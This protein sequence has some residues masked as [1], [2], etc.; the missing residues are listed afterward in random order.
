MEAEFIN[1]DLTCTEAEWIRNLLINLPLSDN[2][3]P[4]ISIHCDN[5][6]AI[7]KAKNANLNEKIRHIRIRHNSIK[8]LLSQG[9]VVL[10][11]VRSENNTTN[12]F[13]KD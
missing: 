9:V 4:A 13:T 2:I 6:A 7:A 3:I 10:D 5:E 12:P 1:L 11:F 8:Q